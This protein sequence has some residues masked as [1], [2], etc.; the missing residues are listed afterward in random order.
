MSNSGVAKRTLRSECCCHANPLCTE[1]SHQHCLTAQPVLKIVTLRF[2]ISSQ[3]MNWWL[4]LHC[5]TLE[6]SKRSFVAKCSIKMF[7]RID[8]NAGE[9]AGLSQ[10]M[11]AAK[12][13]EGQ[14]SP[15]TLSYQLLPVF[16][17]AYDHFCASATSS[18]PVSV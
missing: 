17:F 12:V 3:K 10:S 8:P 15:M 2:S 5:P 18:F 1:C 4:S 6:N 16:Q 13:L 9:I 11:S 7:R 14:S